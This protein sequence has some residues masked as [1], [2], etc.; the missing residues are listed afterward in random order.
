M[1][2]AF[3]GRPV[4][5]SDLCIPWGADGAVPGGNALWF[6][7]PLEVGI[8]TL[9]GRVAETRAVGSQHVTVFSDS[10]A[11][12][13]QILGTATTVDTDA[14]GC[15]TRAVV[16]PTGGTPGMHPESLSV[17]VYAQDTGT[18]TLLWSGQLPGHVAEEYVDAVR[19]SPLAPGECATTPSG[20]WVALG[21]HGSDGTRWD[22]V[23]LTCS[24]IRSVGGAQVALTPA[25][26]TAWATGGVTAYVPEPLNAGA[27]LQPYFRPRFG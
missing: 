8:R 1:Q 13:R 10:S 23:D 19:A 12:R 27:D 18:A 9:G 14:N 4:M 25:T 11:L 5:M 3:T 20:T 22:L 6:A 17:C 15:P 26:V 2:T 16:R 7:S 21:L 24:R